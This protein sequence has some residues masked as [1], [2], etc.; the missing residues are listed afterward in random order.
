MATI[1]GVHPLADIFPM[2]P[3]A[4]LDDLAESIH[5]N[6]L[7]NPVVVTT[8]GLILD[9][10]NRYAA[11]QKVGIVPETVEY[12]GD[13]LAEYVLDCN[14]TRR[15]MG[16][17]ARAMATALVLAADGRREGGRWKRGSLDIGPE[18]DNA[19]ALTRALQRAGIVLDWAP[20]LADQ[21]VAGTFDLKNAYEIAKQ[22]RDA[23][24][25]EHRAKA[26]EAQRKRE[27]TI[28]EKEDNDRKL[29]V[30]TAD[31]SPFLL[32]VED[33]TMTIAVAYAAHQEATRKEREAQK[34][35]EMGWR[36]GC[37]SITESVYKLKGGQQAGAQYLSYFHPHEHDY[38]PE[39]L[40]LTRARV[41]DAIDTL[42][43]IL[44]G[45]PR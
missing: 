2:L 45:L 8:D 33:Q 28:R 40:Q 34:E 35:R 25:A 36:D 37:R 18:S 29:A 5:T 32:Q 23:V 12:G 21:V 19:T 20:D 17:G 30:L 22:K 38:I 4:E 42:T 14:I 44:E 43:T 39:N 26:I 7:R 15:N 6:G 31:A 9:G 13:D 1:T 3:D 27:A 41:Q 24:D 10:R 16:A 11:C